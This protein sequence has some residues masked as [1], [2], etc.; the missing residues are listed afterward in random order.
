MHVFLQLLKACF[1]KDFDDD[2]AELI[3][4]PL[5]LLSQILELLALELRDGWV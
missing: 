1:H 4:V 3:Y 5:E 2:L